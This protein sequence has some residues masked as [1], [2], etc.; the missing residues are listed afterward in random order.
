MQIVS[1]EN[2]YATLKRTREGEEN[3][4]AGQ[5]GV[6]IAPNDFAQAAIQL[7]RMIKNGMPIENF[8]G[9][10]LDDPRSAGRKMYLLIN[11]GKDDLA[12]IKV[13]A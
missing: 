12:C 6:M 9:L 10:L 1:I 3:I 13:A 5:N 7:N 8:V 11:D 4:A 2:G